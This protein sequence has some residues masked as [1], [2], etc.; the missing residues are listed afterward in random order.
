MPTFASDGSDLNERPG[1]ITNGPGRWWARPGR[2]SLAL[3]VCRPPGPAAP[4]EPRR[5]TPTRHLPMDVLGK[6]SSSM[7]TVTRR[8]CPPDSPDAPLAASPM[9]ESATRS[10]S[11]LV[12]TFSTC[13]WAPPA[14]TCGRAF[15]SQPTQH[16]PPR[17]GGSGTRRR[18]RASFSDSVMLLGSRS[19]AAKSSV[20]RTVRCG[21]STSDCITYA[22]SR[23]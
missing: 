13:G 17:C 20:S 14:E 8:F 5:R 11:R 23:R 22:D 2:A 3:D 18:T 16:L 15:D 7:P 19:L 1:R 12:M 10:S 6:V 9:R 4:R 21:N